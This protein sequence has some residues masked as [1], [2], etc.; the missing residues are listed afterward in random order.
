MAPARKLKIEL[1]YDYWDEDGTRH[2]VGAVISLPEKDAAD[3]V[4]IG[5]AKLVVG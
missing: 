3:M 5:K 1:L 2:S 4:N